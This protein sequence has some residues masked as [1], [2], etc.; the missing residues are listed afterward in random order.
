[1]TLR[2]WLPRLAGQRGYTAIEMIV[3]MALTTIISG[4]IFSSF[5]VLNRVQTDWENRDQ[6]QAVGVVAEQSIVRDMHAY[7]PL[8]LGADSLELTSA[9]A[10]P[11]VTPNSP[12][13]YVCYWIH[14]SDHLLRRSSSANNTCSSSLPPSTPNTVVAHGVT[15]FTA[16]CLDA[17]GKKIT[18]TG[19]QVPASLQIQ[20][21]IDAIGEGRNTPP[22]DVDPP[23][24]LTPRN[25]PGSVNGC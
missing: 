17:N 2:T 21:K 4:T 16:T 25:V 5:L 6:A 15:H 9:S 12:T 11:L 10:A 13:Y 23:M 7:P 1:M 14:G 18:G 24:R 3:T 19:V 20:M 22:F 8:R